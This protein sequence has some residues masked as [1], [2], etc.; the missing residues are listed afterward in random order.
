MQ[1]LFTGTPALLPH[2]KAGKMRALAVFSVRHIAT[3]PDVPAVAE[4]KAAGTAG[5]DADQ[6]YGVVA[7]SGTPAAIVALLNAEVNKALGSA[8]VVRR[9]SSEGAEPTPARPAEFGQLIN[10][11]VKRR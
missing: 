10:R 4:S 5:F 3:L 1:A 2:I 7:P 6:W 8:D 9:F 11:E